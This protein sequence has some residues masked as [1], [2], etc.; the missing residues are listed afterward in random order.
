MRIMING[1]F[2]AFLTFMLHFIIIDWIW[3]MLEI[4]IDGKEN[5]ER[6]ADFINCVIWS[7]QSNGHLR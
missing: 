2:Q 4:N 7:K 6:E 5:G 3:K 1:E